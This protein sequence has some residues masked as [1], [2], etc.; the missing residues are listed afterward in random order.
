MAQP[1][2]DLQSLVGSRIRVCWTAPRA[3]TPTLSFLPGGHGRSRGDSSLFDD[4]FLSDST[5]DSSDVV[6]VR[7]H[8]LFLLFTLLDGNAICWRH[9]AS[10]AGGTDAHPNGSIRPW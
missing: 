7:S 1:I 4:C 2:L 6:G 3:A 8:D 5:K 9:G 10:L